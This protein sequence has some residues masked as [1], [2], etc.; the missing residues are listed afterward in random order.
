MLDTPELLRRIPKAELHVHLGGMMTGD[1]FFALYDKYRSRGEE[2]F[3]DSQ[4]YSRIS[5]HPALEKF[6]RSGERPDSFD[7]LLRAG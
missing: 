2:P 5:H 1:A 4:R 6:L 3:I 7:D